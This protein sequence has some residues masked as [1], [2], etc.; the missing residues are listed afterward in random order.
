MNIHFRGF[1]DIEECVTLW[2]LIVQR[3][4]CTFHQHYDLSTFVSQLTISYLV[5][6]SCLHRVFIQ[7]EHHG[8]VKCS[9]RL[10]RHGECYVWYRT[11]VALLWVVDKFPCAQH[12]RIV[13]MSYD[14][15]RCTIRLWISL[16]LCHRSAHRLKSCWRVVSSLNTNATNVDCRNWLTQNGERYAWYRICVTLLRVM[17]GL[18]MYNI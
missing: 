9:E 5:D 14:R 4:E 2:R 8:H 7:Y 1:G 17:I 16:Q 3:F 11:C 13:G 6:I 15:Y 18:F 10:S 12:H